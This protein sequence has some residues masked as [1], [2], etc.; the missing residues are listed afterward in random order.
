MGWGYGVGYVKRG[1]GCRGWVVRVGGS[2]ENG[3]CVA[4]EGDTCLRRKVENAGK[5]VGCMCSVLCTPTR[6]G[7]V[8]GC[9]LA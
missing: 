2:V 6:V 5:Q 4:M 7:V 3:R 9:G 8:L 1:G